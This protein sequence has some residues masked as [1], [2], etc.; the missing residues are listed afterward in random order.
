MGGAL[1][2]NGDGALAGRALE[3]LDA[4]SLHSM[5]VLNHG[6]DVMLLQLCSKHS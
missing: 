5:Q 6:Y 4:A 2:T 1:E 3:V